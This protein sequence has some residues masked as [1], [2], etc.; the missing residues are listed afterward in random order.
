MHIYQCDYDLDVQWVLLFELES[1]SFPEA[2]YKQVGPSESER[3][4][5]A[6]RSINWIRRYLQDVF[7][8]DLLSQASWKWLF[9]QLILSYFY[10]VSTEEKKNN[11]TKYKFLFFYFAKQGIHI[12]HLCLDPH[13]RFGNC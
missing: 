2:Q 10:L 7:T 3:R 13:S 6:V 4:V 1:V 12:E 5:H 8:R 9:E 11:N